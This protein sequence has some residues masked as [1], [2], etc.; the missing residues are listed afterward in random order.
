M[1]LELGKISSKN[2]YNADAFGL[3][4]YSFFEQGEGSTLA[5]A[6]CSQIVTAGK[7]GDKTTVS[8]DDIIG[9]NS[10][11]APE[12]HGFAVKKRYTL[13]EIQQLA[14]AICR[15]KKSVSSA[16][17]SQQVAPKSVEPIPQG[18]SSSSGV[19]NCP[20]W[21]KQNEQNRDI[22]PDQKKPQGKQTPAAQWSDTK[23]YP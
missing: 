6:I 4:F 12:K 1:A 13:D 8:Y 7:G 11:Y 23:H 22:P 9:V 5:E 19:P 21:Q 15:N 14:E 20:D 17:S 16:V 18:S 2:T 3:N 10:A